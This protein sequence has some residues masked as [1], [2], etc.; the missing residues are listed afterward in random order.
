MEIKKK[1]R[2]EVKRQVERQKTD[3]LQEK[4]RC[5]K[6]EKAETRICRQIHCNETKTRKRKGPVREK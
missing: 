2:G 1:K 4:G 3:K 6:V 5:G